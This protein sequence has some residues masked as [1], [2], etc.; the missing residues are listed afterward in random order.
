MSRIDSHFINEMI[1]SQGVE[2]VAKALENAMDIKLGLAFHI[3]PS[4]KKF[5]RVQY[6]DSPYEDWGTVVSISVVDNMIHYGVRWDDGEPTDLFTD[7]Q[8][9][10]VKS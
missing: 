2:W 1:K 8:I 7:S 5:D 3:E 10:K 6:K 9:E 4:F